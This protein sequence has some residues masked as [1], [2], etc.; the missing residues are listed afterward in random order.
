MDVVACVWDAHAVLDVCY[1]QHKGGYASVT[2][3]CTVDKY[4]ITVLSLD[5][6]ILWFK[7]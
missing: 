7:V 4:I 6:L 2:P 5:K 1:H 3:K